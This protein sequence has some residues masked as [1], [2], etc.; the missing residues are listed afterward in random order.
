MLKISIN[1]HIFLVRFTD[2]AKIITD[3]SLTSQESLPKFSNAGFV[4]PILFDSPCVELT[5]NILLKKAS[6]KSDRTCSFFQ[7]RFY[8]KIFQTLNRVFGVY[9]LHVI[10]FPLYVVVGVSEKKQFR[11]TCCL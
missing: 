8:F 4:K 2:F 10:Y 3:I 5:L 7:Q 6:G 1:P 9:I 11:C